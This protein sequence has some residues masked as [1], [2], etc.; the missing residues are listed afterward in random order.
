MTEFATRIRRTELAATFAMAA[1]ARALRAEGKDV[2]SLSLGEPDFPTPTHVVDAA[3]A[4]A[5]RG[6][7]KYPPLGGIEPLRAAVAAKFTR[8]HGVPVSPQEVLITNGGKQGI[9]NMVMSLIGTGDEVIIPAPAWA[10]YEQTVKFAGGVP[11]FVPCPQEQGFVLQPEALAKA[12]TGRTKLLLLNYPSNPSGATISRDAL[13]AL[14][15]VLRQYPHVWVLSDDIYEHLL[16]GGAQHHTL[17]GVAPDLQ[18]RVITLSGVS[19]TYAMTGW[20]IGWCIAPAEMIK[21]ATV[22]Q[23]TATSGVSSIGQAASLAA[24]TGP[25]DFLAERVAAYEQRRNTVVA[26]LN[27]VPGVA[28]HKPDGAFYVFP[29]IAGCL[30]KTTPHGRLI[31]SDND[32]A[33]A[34]LEDGLVGVVQGSAFALSPHIR[35]STATALPRLQEACQRIAAFCQTLT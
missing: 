15:D 21:A 11:V 35:I 29:N 2:I 30:D 7:T 10:G 26:A 16:F 33:M 22:V 8:E 5:Q 25:Q 19:K 6:E 27:Q 17:L 13:A 23:A 28:C 3:Y 1:R 32:F 18:D 20:R 4:A 24:L 34:L 31:R 9:F 12:I 14:A